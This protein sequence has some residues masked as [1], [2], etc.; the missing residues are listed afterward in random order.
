[1]N[2]TNSKRGNDHTKIEDQTL[3]ELNITFRPFHCCSMFFCWEFQCFTDGYV[4]LRLADCLRV[5][6]LVKI[7]S[8]SF[9]IKMESPIEK[10]TDDALREVFSLLDGKSLKKA[11]LMCKK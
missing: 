9:K 2:A 5:H 6:I 4:I 8:S 11:A 3:K 10:L 1:M 7:H